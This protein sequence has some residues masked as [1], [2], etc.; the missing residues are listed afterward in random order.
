MVQ[1]NL[2]SKRLKGKII[3]SSDCE[4]SLCTVLHVGHVTLDCPS[5]AFSKDEANP[6]TFIHNLMRILKRFPYNV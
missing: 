4:A 2:D 6:I 3:L 5:K 1:G